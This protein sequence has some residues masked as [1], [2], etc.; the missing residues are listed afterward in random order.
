MDRVGAEAAAR[1]LG[2]VLRIASEI[3]GEGTAA[4]D[5]ELRRAMHR[6]I[7][8]VTGGIESFG[9][10]AAIARLYAFT[11]VL[12]KS[13]AGPRPSARRCGCWHN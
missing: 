5:L 1:H 13:Q 3:S 10:N 2:R 11:N 12:Q 7:H 9:F 4:A 8:E 6:T